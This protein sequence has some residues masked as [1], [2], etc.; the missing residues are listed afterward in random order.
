MRELKLRITE[1]SD[2]VVKL[3][4]DFTTDVNSTQSERN[5]AYNISRMIKAM[6]APGALAMG[7]GRTL[8]DAEQ[9]YDI[10]DSIRKAGQ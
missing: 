10:Q 1:D 4:C 5:A 8:S 7:W 2:G 6:L 3:H 9:A